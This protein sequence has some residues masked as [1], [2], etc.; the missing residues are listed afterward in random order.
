MKL[1]VDD[2]DIAYDRAGSGEAVILVMGLG[3]TRIGWFNQFR[4][5]QERYDVTAF[6]NRGTGESGRPAGEWTMQDMAGDVVRVADA[7][8]Y[9]RFHLAGVSMGGMISQEVALAVPDRLRSLTL[10]STSPGGPQATLASPE[11]LQAFMLPDPRD[12]VRRSIELLFGPRYREEHPEIVQAAV[13]FALHGG[14]AS[15]NS[16]FDGEQA[17]SPGFMGQLT[18]IM[19]WSLHGGTA[20]RLGEITAPTLVLHGGADNLVPLP[21]GQLLAD[22]IPGARFRV[23]DDAGHALIQEYAND[24]NDELAKHLEAASVSA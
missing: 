9:E 18:A 1:R 8:G 24:V 11:Y 3:T 23:W 7:M 12:R 16:F 5:L 17:D 22:G 10:I 19:N 20:A 14:T 13:D 2:F 6:D 4:F 21:N 15:A